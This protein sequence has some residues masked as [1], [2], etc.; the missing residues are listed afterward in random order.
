[1][2]RRSLHLLCLLIL[3]FGVLVGSGAVQAQGEAWIKVADGVRGVQPT[4]YQP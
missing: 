1:M 2:R 4:S 3:V